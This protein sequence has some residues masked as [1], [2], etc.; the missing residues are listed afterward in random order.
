VRRLSV[1]VEAGCPTCAS[2][3]RRVKRWAAVLGFVV[4]V[5]D[6]E[7]AGW[8]NT[9]A[10][11]CPVVLAADGRVLAAGRLR[12]LGRRLLGERLCS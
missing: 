7:R 10:D 2:G 1:I 9:A 12:G 11:R 5:L 3:L 4:G 6:G 8:E